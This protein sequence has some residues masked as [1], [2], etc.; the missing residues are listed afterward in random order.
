MPVR[1]IRRSPRCLWV[2]VLA[3]LLA[4]GLAAC[5]GSSED[6]PAPAEPALAAPAPPAET[7][8]PPTL[9]EAPIP[10]PPAAPGEPPVP[11]APTPPAT[12]TS[13][14]PPPPVESP[15]GDPSAA[16]DEAETQSFRYDTYDLSGAVAEP[17]HYT[18]LA[19]PADP[20]SAVTTYE[21][22]RDGTATALRIHPHDAHGTSQE[23]F[24][25]NV[26][27]G[28]LVEWKQ[29]DD[30]F[31][32]Y[33]V[34][35]APTP[36]A[37]ATTQ[38]FGVAWMT[39]A[40]TGCSGAISTTA[41]TDVDVTWG[42]VLPVLG[43][44]SLT[45]PIRHGPWQI[46]PA[47][48]TGDLVASE[49]HDPPAYNRDNPRGTS[50][51]AVARTYPYWR[52][53]ALPDHWVLWSAAMDPEDLPYG[54]RAAWGP[55]PWDGSG[56]LVLLAG[57]L[58]L[59]NGAEDATAANNYVRETRVIAGRPAEILYP[60]GGTARHVRIIIYDP[61]T[62]AAYRIGTANPAFTGENLDA[63]ID[64]ARSLFEPPNSP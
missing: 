51:P 13:E 32:R 3:L 26:A 27:T 4:S 47:D 23:V 54:Y 61:A 35:E 20:A 18:F 60:T 48:W 34:T 16:T 40:F 6:A 12:A 62:E 22:L 63:L 1:R 19:D 55:E 42:A 36:A 8:P 11:D 44:T 39:Y 31:V 29:A 25:D 58:W 28:D 2:C 15:T 56:R 50:D 33:T 21:G 53:P 9:P 10:A 41:A 17:G 57:F 24:Y 59:R 38:L 43:G 5:N 45:A 46:A 7:P 49:Q 37:G 64:L 30:C 14:P 52:E